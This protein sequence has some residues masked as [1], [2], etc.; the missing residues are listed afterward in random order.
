[1]LP[2]PRSHVIGIKASLAFSACPS[3]KPAES[4]KSFRPNITVP[5]NVKGV[6][7]GLW[8]IKECKWY[9]ERGIQ[10]KTVESRLLEYNIEGVAARFRKVF[11]TRLYYLVLNDLG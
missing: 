9:L 4:I 8:K 7:R 2:N 5:G 10:E 3:G 6:Y 1:M 11:V